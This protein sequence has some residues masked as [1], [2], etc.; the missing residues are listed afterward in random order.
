[1]VADHDGLIPYLS[2]DRC[3]KAGSLG[4]PQFPQD[5]V[6]GGGQETLRGFELSQE[7]QGLSRIQMA[8][9]EPLNARSLVGKQS[10]ADEDASL[11]GLQ[12]SL[13]MGMVDQH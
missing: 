5:K 1:L 9:I 12:F 10:I 4:R 3:G 6:T 11:Y 7:P 8:R 13:M 2:L